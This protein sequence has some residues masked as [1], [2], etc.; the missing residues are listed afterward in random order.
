MAWWSETIA[1][2]SR[3]S[4]LGDTWS[5]EQYSLAWFR[6]RHHNCQCSVYLKSVHRQHTRKWRLTG[7]LSIHLRQCDL[8]FKARYIRPGAFIFRCKFLYFQILK[9]SASR[10]SKSWTLQINNQQ[11]RAWCSLRS[12][13]MWSAKEVWQIYAATCTHLPRLMYPLF[14][15]G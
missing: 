1:F 10:V 12:P 8:L 9:R 13:I 11:S 14:K 4:E 7:S 6:T 2:G 15:D 5:L 3:D